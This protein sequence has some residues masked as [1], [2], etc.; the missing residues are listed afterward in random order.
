MTSNDEKRR[1]NNAIITE[2]KKLFFNAINC[3]DDKSVLT[4]NN[5]INT[6][7][8]HFWA[9]TIIKIKIPYH[10]HKNYFRSNKKNAEK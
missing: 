10:S 8:E 3:N 1:R 7:Y 6:K 9:Q 2:R 5:D 4:Y